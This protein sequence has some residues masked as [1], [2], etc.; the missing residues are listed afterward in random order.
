MRT[1]EQL[2]EAIKR[3]K[4]LQ[5]TWKAEASKMRSAGFPMAA[6]GCLQAVENHK[7]SVV[8]CESE[9]EALR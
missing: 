6:E 8:V 9:L 5:K 4:E 7:R 3:H 2:I 1:R